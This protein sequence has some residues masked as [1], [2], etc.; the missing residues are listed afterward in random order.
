MKV[1]FDFVTNSSSTSFIIIPY[2]EFTLENFIEAIGLEEQ[3]SFAPIFEDLFSS[4]SD[5]METIE[6]YSH[7]WMNGDESIESF[8]ERI[9]S[10]E[11]LS[12][13]Q[14]AQKKG[15]QVYIG[16]LYSDNGETECFF[17]TDAFIIDSKKIFVDAT[18]DGW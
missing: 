13:V 5:K 16:E 1:K 15:F 6:G 8:V 9:F 17:C 11:T 12:K 14:E 4:F 18:N 3:S 10:K 2:E 7:R